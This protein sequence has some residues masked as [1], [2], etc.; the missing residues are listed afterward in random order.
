MC[1]AKYLTFIKNFFY[2]FPLPYIK[3][4][5][6]IEEIEKE[7]DIEILIFLEL[8][9]QEYD[10]LKEIRL[11]IKKKEILEKLYVKDM[12]REIEEL[13][14]IETK[15]EEL[16]MKILRNWCRNETRGLKI[17]T[18]QEIELKTKETKKEDRIEEYRIIIGAVLSN[19]EDL[20]IRLINKLDEMK[21]MK[22]K[23]R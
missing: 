5:S 6:S 9:E 12:H 8:E 22:N 23:N 7:Y 13:K 2:F 19:A 14:E 16:E 15:L 18:E 17:L 3:K 21:E 11:E 20:K 4:I 1:I 10:K